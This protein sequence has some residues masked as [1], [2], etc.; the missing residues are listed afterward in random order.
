MR[1]DM[2][3]QQV[4]KSTLRT[5][6]PLLAAEAVE[7]MESYQFN[8]PVFFV[9][10]K[11]RCRTLDFVAQ[12]RWTQIKIA[13][14]HDGKLCLV[15]GRHDYSNQPKPTMPK[16]PL[17][18]LVWFF[19]H[20]AFGVTLGPLWKCFSRKRLGTAAYCLREIVDP[21]YSGYDFPIWAFTPKSGRM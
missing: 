9:E 21:L 20:H 8:Q 15:W 11:H 6:I 18:R 19:R 16:W 1:M 14:R 5:S 17:K 3:M 7:V 4:R 12:T 10:G 2:S 13:L